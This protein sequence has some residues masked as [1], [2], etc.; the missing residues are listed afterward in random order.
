VTGKQPIV[1]IQG[2]TFT[3]ETWLKVAVTAPDGTTQ[4]WNGA[5]EDVA[6]NTY[7]IDGLCHNA[8]PGTF[9]HE[10]GKPATF[11]GTRADSFTSG[12]CDACKAN[13]WE[14]SRYTQWEKIK[15]S[16]R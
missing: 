8:E 7:A 6:I 2:R 13:G 14:P 10:C 4:E 15:R 3:A 12:F 16:A 5:Y 1:T 9:N 11:I